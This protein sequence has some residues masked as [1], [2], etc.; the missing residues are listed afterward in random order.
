MRQNDEAK[1]WG[2]N[3][4]GKTMGQDDGAGRWGRTMGQD[5]GAGRWGQDDG[6]KTIE[7]R[8]MEGSVMGGGMMENFAVRVDVM[9]GRCGKNRE[10]SRLKSFCPHRFAP[11]YLAAP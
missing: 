1:R 10:W 9:A 8:M 6:G 7:G 4:G 2:Q 11:F 3:D 5:D